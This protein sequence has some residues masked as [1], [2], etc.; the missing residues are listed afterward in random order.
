MHGIQKK[1]SKELLDFFHCIILVIGAS[2]AGCY[3]VGEAA[4]FLTKFK[5]PQIWCYILLPHQTQQLLHVAL[6]LFS[7][8]LLPLAYFQSISTCSLYSSQNVNNHN[9]V[10][11]P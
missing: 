3:A 11:H 1:R 7:F 9:V 8:T 10:A 6:A 4:T 5:T 2:R